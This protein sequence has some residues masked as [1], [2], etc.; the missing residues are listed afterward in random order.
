M[1]LQNDKTFK[2]FKNV[3]N[4]CKNRVYLVDPNG[5]QFTLNSFPSRYIAL[6]KLLDEDGDKLE[7]FCDSKS[8][9]G[10]F[11]KFFKENPGV[12]SA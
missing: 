3:V 11:L 5:N 10:L 4:Q 2:A 12:L 9:E 7:L 8:D 6:G 1:K